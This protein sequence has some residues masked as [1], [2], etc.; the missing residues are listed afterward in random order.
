MPGRLIV[1]GVFSVFAI[2]GVSCSNSATPTA[3]AVLEKRTIAAGPV[4]V[5]ITPTQLDERGA[6]FAIVLDTHAL[7]LS[8]DIAASAVLDVNGESWVVAGWS[9]DGPSGHHRAGELRFEPGGSARGTARLTIAGSGLPMNAGR[10][11]VPAA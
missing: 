3:A 10:P 4:K 6:T 1:A 2:I 5:S 11:Q 7:E 8:M 9:G